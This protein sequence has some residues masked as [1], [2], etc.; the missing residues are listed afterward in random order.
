M[1]DL[2]GL[3]L[4]RN[5]PEVAA[6]LIAAAEEGDMDAQYAAGLVYA[7]GR[8]VEPDLVQSYFWL[9]R[10]M[11]QGDVD[12]EKL[13]RYVA[14]QMSEAEFW[15]ARRLVRLAAQLNVTPGVSSASGP[16]H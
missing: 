14:S 11:E 2:S 16:K 5:D 12:A 3:N 6:R 4:L 7:E 10:A 13:R 8:G 9:T 15:D 1:A